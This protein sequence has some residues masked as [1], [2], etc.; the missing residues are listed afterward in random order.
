MSYLGL[1]NFLN[2]YASGLAEPNKF[3]YYIRFSFLPLNWNQ[4]FWKTIP[5]L[6]KF[7]PS[8]ADLPYNNEWIF[9]TLIQSHSRSEI[10]ERSEY[11]NQNWIVFIETTRQ[12]KWYLTPL[13]WEFSFY[14]LLFEIL[15]GKRI[16]YN[17]VV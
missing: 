6:E 13:V 2:S 1:R 8:K 4:S 3:F 16:S 9:F 10:Q 14:E 11:G 7:L 5:Y 12:R 17:T 15:E